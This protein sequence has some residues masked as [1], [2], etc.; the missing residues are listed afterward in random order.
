MGYAV[1]AER[2]RYVEWRK[3][4]G[5]GVV[6]RELYDHQTDPSEDRNIASDPA[7]KAVVERLTKQLAAGWKENTPPK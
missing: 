3:R 1:R 5:N 7:N 4:D 2:Y 6:A